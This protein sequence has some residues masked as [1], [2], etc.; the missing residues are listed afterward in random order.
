MP[1]TEEAWSFYS[2]LFGDIEDVNEFVNKEIETGMFSYVNTEDGSYLILPNYE[3]YLKVLNPSD[4]PFVGSAIQGDASLY[5]RIA[6]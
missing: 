1:K 5:K 2:E 6:D 3:Y 4:P